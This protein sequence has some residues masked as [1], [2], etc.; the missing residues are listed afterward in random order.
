MAVLR[1]SQQMNNIKDNGQDRCD[2]SPMICLS[3]YSYQGYEFCNTVFLELKQE[4]EI[5]L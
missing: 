4:S 3:F 5:Y 2:A 1:V